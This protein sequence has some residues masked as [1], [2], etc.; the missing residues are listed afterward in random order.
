MT[1]RKSAVPYATIET[2]FLDAGNTLICMNYAWVASELEALGI[3]TNATEIRR[4][5]AAARPA[6]SRR[7]AAGRYS[8]DID[9]FAFHLAQTVTRLEA[10]IP[11]S[12]TLDA[13]AIA[14]RLAATLKKPGEDHRLWSWVLPGVPEA[15]HELRT[16]GLR[17]IV[18]SNS[19]G[20]VARA[21]ADLDLALH[22]DAI[23]DSHVVGFEKPDPRLFAHALRESGA[24]P[25]RTV[26]VGDMY[27]QD[28]QGSRA[29][30][31]HSVLLDPYG[32]WEIEDCE[33]CRDLGELVGR[34]RRARARR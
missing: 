33:R 26:H 14:R 31:V 29:A 21:L 16:L 32:D 4:A 20:S 19:D 7:I 12:A 5:E 30:G 2:I 17:L 1:P 13:S 22:L 10:R 8:D 28:V 23:F 15:L 6:T 18:V 9:H 3:V 24:S 11:L 34:I 25:E 27:Y